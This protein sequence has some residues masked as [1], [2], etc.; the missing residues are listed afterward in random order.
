M[1]WI[2]PACRAALS[3]WAHV[4]TNARLRALRRWADASRRAQDAAAY[5]YAARRWLHR[6][7]LRRWRR[8]AA[9]MTRRALLVVFAL[10]GPLVLGIRTWARRARRQA[11]VSLVRHLGWLSRQRRLWRW[12]AAH[13]SRTLDRRTPAEVLLLPPT[14][15]STRRR[16]SL[17]HGV[18]GAPRSLSPPTA[19]P[20]SATAAGE[21][22]P[23]GRRPAPQQTEPDGAVRFIAPSCFDAASSRLLRLGSGASSVAHTPGVDAPSGAAA[24]ARAVPS[25]IDPARDDGAAS[26][27][28]TTPS[29]SA[30]LARLQEERAT[31][32][33]KVQ[34]AVEVEDFEEAARMEDRR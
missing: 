28:L 26:T 7:L 22:P 17:D 2:S 12:R 16:L 19:R 9:A 25:A 15:A 18:V 10:L 13:V 11:V 8:G 34:A 33:R 3:A 20:A 14:P 29:A 1:R 24:A 27:A 31:A 32:E 21:S 4:R 6:R 23:P 30:A 5:A